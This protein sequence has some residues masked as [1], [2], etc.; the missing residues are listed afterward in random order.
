MP[1]GHVHTSFGLGLG[2]HFKAFQ[3][4]SLA[5]NVPTKVSP[6]VLAITKPPRA[7]SCAIWVLATTKPTHLQPDGLS[8]NTIRTTSWHAKTSPYHI[9]SQ[10]I[11]I[12]ADGRT[13]FMGGRS[14]NRSLDLGMTTN[15]RLPGA[16]RHSL[17]LLAPTRHSSQSG[18]PKSQ[19]LGLL[20]LSRTNQWVTYMK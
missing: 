18:H 6:E 7:P 16:T 9:L 19:S 1:Q 13:V 5:C 14:M 20:L 11:P 8:S 3:W 17:E 4:L 2:D 12:W 15:Q 10:A